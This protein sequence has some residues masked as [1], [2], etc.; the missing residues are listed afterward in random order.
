MFQETGVDTTAGIGHTQDPLDPQE[1]MGRT[2][3]PDP[4]DPQDPQEVMGRTEPPDPAGR[5]G[6][7]HR[8]REVMGR[9][10]PPD[11]QDPPDPQE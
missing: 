9:T 7:S 11:P 5:A 2:E 8:T 3:P 6:R 1:V 10:E 4:Q